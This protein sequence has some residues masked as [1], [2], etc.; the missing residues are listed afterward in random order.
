[1][2]KLLLTSLFLCAELTA[3]EENFVEGIFLTGR[4]D[5]VIADGRPEVSGIQMMDIDLPG[6]EESLIE[7]LQCYLGQP[8]T[9]EIA[10]EIK[11]TII[12]Y[13]I[14]CGVT[15]VGVAAPSQMTEGGVIQ[16]LITRKR[17]GQ[18][19]FCG[20]SF[21]NS[22]C[23]YNYLCV[24]PGEEVNDCVLQSNLS[25]L[26]K[27]PFHFSKLRF[28][29]TDDPEVLD[30][31]VTAKRRRA[32]RFFV[33]GDDTGSA[34]TGY[35]RLYTGFVWGNAFNRGDIF[36]FEYQTS[37]EFKRLQAWTANY[38]CFLPWQHTVL[39]YGTYAIVKPEPPRPLPTLL[40]TQKINAHA[41]QIKPRYIIPFWP[42]H[43]PLQQSLAFGFDVKNTN[44]SII[45]FTGTTVEVQ[46]P[47]R[48]RMRSQIYVTQLVG[49]Y[50][51]YDTWGCHDYLFNMSF[52]LSPFKFLPH[53]TTRD[54]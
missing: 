13:Y 36:S 42:H 38:T 28:V 29:A 32:L 39:L 49:S 9:R 22:D 15:M 4:S 47:S 16:F 34:R 17:V 24:T 40:R 43:T 3:V 50:S 53:Q 52:Y 54:Y 14:R 25:W 10:I 46:P 8:V 2:S 18:I 27:N 30:I 31:E 11:R 41:W 23:L 26:N 5:D 20:E 7:S 1:M 44:S 51:R 33:K 37:N 35:G 45:N 19:F 12:D 6:C 48:F 21:Y